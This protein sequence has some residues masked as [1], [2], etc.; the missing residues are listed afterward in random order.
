[1]NKQIDHISSETMAALT[2]YPWPGNIRELQN[3]IERCLILTSGNVLE[4]PLS[5]LREAAEVESLGPITMED[6]MRHH[7]LKILEQTRW[8]VSGPSG[9]PARLGLTSPTLHSRMQ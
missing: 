9:A 8:V 4:S 5:S 6:A 1:M 2:S 7:I 3:F